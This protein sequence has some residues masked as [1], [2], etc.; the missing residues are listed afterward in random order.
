MSFKRPVFA[1]AI[2]TVFLIVFT[3]GTAVRTSTAD[4]DQD[5]QES[6]RAAIDEILNEPDLPS[7]IW[8]IYVRDLRTG[9][10]VFSRNADKNL[11]PAS[12]MKLFTTATALGV[13]GSNHRYIT[14]LYFNGD[15]RSDGTL[16]GD[17]II[18]GSGDP[19]FGS[20]H[21]SIDPLETWARE[22]R[23][24]GIRRIEGRIIG[25]DDILED[26]PY[27]EGWDVWHVATEDYAPASGGLSYRDNLVELSVSGTRSG[28]RASASTDPSGYA[29]IENRVISSRGGGGSPFRISRALGTNTI[30]LSGSVST[31][32]R[33]TS[34]IPIEN[35]TRFTLHAFVAALEAEGIIVDAAVADLDDLDVEPS[36]DSDPLLVHASP[37]MSELVQ[38]INQR[39]D[40]FYAEQVFRTFAANGTT[41][42]GAQRVLAFL[43]DAGIQTEGLSIRDGSGL[44][45]KDMVTPQ[46]LVGLLEHM[47]DHP[48]RAAFWNSLPE[49]GGSQSTLRSRLRGIP[50]RAK[51]GSLEY[52][53]A[54]SGYVTAPSGNRL[55]FSVIANNYT[56]NGSAIS[57]AA[58]RIVRALATGASVPAE[59]D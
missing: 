57:S 42:G 46:A 51:T 43:N 27:A 4:A 54:L 25:D 47:D 41:R 53:R 8:G 14:R 33:G 6:T 39:S 52:V 24:A 3:I 55:A 35:P 30:E 38:R 10:V 29:Q 32:Y 48:E 31:R 2:L 59:E 45:R 22:L 56:T 17:L 28:S 18:R 26:N 20:R 21:E 40:N 11:V 44:S 7:A 34:H 13:F 5:L 9:R 49:G 1:P 36:Y 37:P 19:A 58:D 15:T 50:V 12:N 23:Q 16:D